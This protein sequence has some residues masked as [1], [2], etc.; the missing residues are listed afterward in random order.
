VLVPGGTSVRP[1]LVLLT[2]GGGTGS[3]LAL[4][5][6][7]GMVAARSI[8]EALEAGLVSAAANFVRL[9]SGCPFWCGHG[10]R[11]RLWSCLVPGGLAWG[12]LVDWWFNG[13]G[14]DDWCR[15]SVSRFVCWCRGLWWSGHHVRGDVRRRGEKD[16]AHGSLRVLIWPLVATNSTICL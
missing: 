2:R 8:G 10:L 3:R 5:D 16:V 11:R 7:L 15:C 13:G 6:I 4:S 14:V 12:G 9:S 1:L